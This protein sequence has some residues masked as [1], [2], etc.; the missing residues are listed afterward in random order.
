METGRIELE[1]SSDALLDNEE[2]K[3]KYL[4]G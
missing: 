3:V 4:G 2:V 1:G